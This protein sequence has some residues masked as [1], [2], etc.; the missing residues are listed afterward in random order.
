MELT[1]RQIFHFPKDLR[2]ALCA[3]AAAGLLAGP[4]AAQSDPAE[5][6]ALVDKLSRVERDLRD[7]QREVY[8]GERPDGGGFG[9]QAPAFG[10]AAP[11][12]SGMSVRVLE[13]E[14]E[15]RLLTGRVEELQYEL[16]RALDRLEQFTDDAEYRL[17]ALESGRAGG[18]AVAGGFGDGRTA[19]Q[20]RGFSAQDGFGQQRFGES[21]VRQGGNQAGNPAA[22]FG[23]ER[24]VG[25]NPQTDRFG[26][27][28]ADGFGRPGA[29]PGA[30]DAFGSSDPE[31][32]AGAPLLQ[33]PLSGASSM[34]V[35]LP[36]DPD[37]LFDEGYNL[38]LRGDYADAEMRFSAFVEA[39]PEHERAPEAQHR[40]GE[41]QFVQGAFGDAATSFLA[42]VQNYPR[43]ERAPESLLRL[44][45]SLYELGEAAEACRTYN[46]LEQRYP[47]A[48][49]TVR[50]RLNVE[51]R[52]AG[53]E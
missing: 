39:F 24:R 26:A 12:D 50:Q 53:C 14:R 28:R 1:M 22:P 52:R 20:D 45:M 46:S 37:A 43:S 9:G 10:Q 8:A 15:L 16:R 29:E 6:R 51:R 17:Q 41:T 5:L 47:N 36:G 25:D 32:G 38:L 21:A 18:P 33:G 3:A 27:G 4:A 23:A 7:L 34:S 2:I 11:V 30:G 44:G 35:S 19:T 40:L 31:A 42:S 13:L 48:S 49:Q